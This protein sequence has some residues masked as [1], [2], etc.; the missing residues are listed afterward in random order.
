MANKPALHARTA[1]G[2]A[3]RTVENLAIVRA[4]SQEGNLKA[5]W[6]TQI[7]LSTLGVLVMPLE[8]LKSKQLIKRIDGSPWKVEDKCKKKAPFL[9][10]VRNAV[11]HGNINIY[12]TKFPDRPS[13]SRIPKEV[14]VRLTDM[15]F[16]ETK[17]CWTVEIRADELED[18]V[19]DLHELLRELAA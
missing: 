1:F 10:H 9:Q 18:L 8:E 17:V 2:I 13:K 19:E 14:T 6:V 4:Q 3:D 7:V 11:A 5:H 15:E 12:D 16:G